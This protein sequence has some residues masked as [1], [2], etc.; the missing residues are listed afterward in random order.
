[1]DDAKGGNL[2]VPDPVRAAAFKLKSVGQVAADLVEADG[3]QY[4]V[5]LNGITAAHKRSLAEADRAIR[6]LLIQEKMRRSASARSRTSCARSSPSRS[7]S[8]RS[9]P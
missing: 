8:A 9:R 5:R 4:V 7:T 1:M 6:V 3:K 2:K